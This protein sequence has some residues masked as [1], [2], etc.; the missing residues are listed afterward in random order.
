MHDP[1]LAARRADVQEE[2]LVGLVEHEHVVGLRRAETMA[3][4]LGRPHLLV[5]PGVEQP[6]AVG[7]PGDAAPRRGVRSARRADR[8]RW[9]GRGPA[10]CSA[11]RRRGRTTRRAACGPATDRRR[12]RRRSRGPRPRRCSR[13]S[14]IVG[15]SGTAGS[16]CGR[17]PGTTGP[18]SVR[19]TYHQPPWRTGTDR[20]V[21]WTRDR[22]SSKIVVDQRR[23]AGSANHAAGV[24]VLRL[25]VGDRRRVVAVAQPRPGVVDG[26]G[27]A[28]PRVR[29]GRGH[30]VRG[31]SMLCHARPRLRPARA[32]CP[33]RGR[34]AGT[35][36][37]RCACGST[38]TC[39]PATVCASTTAPTCSSSSRTAS[40]TS[41]R[42][43]GRSTTRAARARWRGC[44]IR[45]VQQVIHAAEDCPG[46]CIFIE[47]D[48]P[49]RRRPRRHRRRAH[50]R[51]HRASA[52][53]RRSPD[54]PIAIGGAAS[55]GGAG[56]RILAPC[57]CARSA[58]IS[59]AAPTPTAR[60]CASA[61][62]T[63]RP[64][65]PW[66]CPDALRRRTSAGSPTGRGRTAPS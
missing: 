37:P 19:V 60:R 66:R 24:G 3:P 41:R 45:H 64:T 57:R 62:S 40:P 63:S 47:I 10:A 23:S 54:S 51:P 21:S 26:A 58:S 30:A 53:T 49:R 15:S 5:G 32:S 12:G 20:S 34:T 50:R 14:P 13:A 29:A 25:E 4:D 18:R 59:R 42:P 52:T 56:R 38:R 1:L 11:R 35:V 44:P 22:I 55:R 39:A 46:E 27:R 9:R 2:A 36:R 31:T 6:R 43:A 61:T 8:R 17:T 16:C 48:A 33:G 28:V 7:R 65:R